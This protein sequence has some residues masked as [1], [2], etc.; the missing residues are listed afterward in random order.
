MLT[1]CDYKIAKSK[2][3]EGATN[4]WGYSVDDVKFFIFWCIASSLL[5]SPSPTSWGLEQEIWRSMFF[6]RWILEFFN[7]LDFSESLGELSIR[8]QH[9]QLHQSWF[10]NCSGKG[11]MCN[12]RGTNLTWKYLLLSWST[13]GVLSW[14]FGCFESAI[15]K[16]SGHMLTLDV[17]WNWHSTFHFSPSF[18]FIRF[19]FFTFAQPSVFFYFQ[20]A[21]NS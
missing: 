13:L 10:Q 12:G 1:D 17:P 7:S 11:K 6:L 14:Y 15:E 19:S 8:T 3:K 4:R 16:A 9:H 2:E 5:S 20:R 21:I 18:W